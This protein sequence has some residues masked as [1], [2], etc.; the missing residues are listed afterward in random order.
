MSYIDEGP[1]DAPTLVMLHGNPT[2]SFYY[3]K[4]ILA[5][6]D[7]WRVIAPDHMGCGLSDKP[8]DYQYT[9]R[10]HVE[11]LTALLDHLGVKELNLVMHDWGGAIG[12]GYAVERPES[13]RSLVIFNTA[14]FRSERIPFRI[15]IFRTPGL[16]ALMARGWNA[17]ALSAIYLRMAT[18]RPERFT[19]TVRKGY[20][21]PYD[22]WKNR[23]AILRFVQD[24]P[25]S[26][27][28]GS[29][30]Y[31]KSIEE[32]LKLFENTPAL[33]LWGMGDF[34]FDRSF[35]DGWLG[36]L[37]NTEARMFEDAGHYVVEDAGERVEKYMSRFLGRIYEQG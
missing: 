20:L 18:K 34:C 5:F 1:K 14:A 13:V 17:F 27:S 6:R 2:W 10:R 9:L 31:L 36:R 33:V 19:E 35:L 32:R 23:V 12:M 11:N 3:R 21:M 16:G 4:L 24:I 8:Q 29:Y 15:R 22:S 28:D 30:E 37:K 26:P 25:L 7:R